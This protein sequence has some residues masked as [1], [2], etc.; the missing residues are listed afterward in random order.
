MRVKVRAVVVRDG[1]LLVS[2]ERRRG[3]D[4][5]L[6]PGGRVRDGETITDALIREVSEET[7]LEVIPK[8]L[9]YVAEVVG[10]Y[11]VHDL[12]LVWLAD[13]R[14]PNIAIDERA[15]VAL[16]S[17]RADAI[18]PP[19]VDQIAADASNGWPQEPRWLGNVRRS[20]LD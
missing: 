20:P 5:V 19:I 6:L 2:R 17:P 10:M 16:D 1:K 15:V 18:M 11:R 7:G 9:L 8:R 12:N 4:H 14:D 13:L 3:R